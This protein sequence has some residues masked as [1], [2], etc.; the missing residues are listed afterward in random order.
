MGVGASC[1]T[2]QRVAAITSVRCL[3]IEVGPGR[4]LA[5]KRAVA[6]MMSHGKESREKSFHPRS[7]YPKFNGN[8]IA[9]YLSQAPPSSQRRVP[10]LLFLS[11]WP[12]RTPGIQRNTPWDS[13]CSN[14]GHFPLPPVY[15]GRSIVAQ[16]L[17]SSHW[18]SSMHCSGEV[19]PFLWARECLFVACA[20]I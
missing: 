19:E 16:A 2:S 9:K 17:L 11:S 18:T 4:G 10:W 6:Q 8:I 12:S 14:W 3:N 1:A 20:S 7:Q 5:K 15:V 13:V